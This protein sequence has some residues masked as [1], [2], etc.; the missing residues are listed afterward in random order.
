MTRT[1]LQPTSLATGCLA[2]AIRKLAS[3]SSVM[4]LL[5]STALA[6]RGAA[7]IV[8]VLQTTFSN[9]T[10]AASDDFGK[11]LGVMGND[12]IVIG[13]PGDD[14]IGSEEG[15]AYLFTLGGDLLTDF[16]GLGLTLAKYGFGQSV[17]PLGDIVYIG[18]AEDY[19]FPNSGMVY[20]C[21]TNGYRER[22]FW[23]ANGFDPH[24]KF[25]AS[26]AALGNER[27]IVGAYGSNEGGSLDSENGA[28]FL[29]ASMN[30]ITSP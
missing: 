4:V 9:P 27:L 30:R 22:R 14:D 8:P 5:L 29:L 10:P 25:S 6:A 1:T 3:V 18:A 17:V 26:V 20:G 23:N 11:A 7:L 19:N 2:A 12:R 15:G 13:A 28:V 21:A 24:S 16:T